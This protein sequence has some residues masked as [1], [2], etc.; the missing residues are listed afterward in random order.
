MIDHIQAIVNSSPD[1]NWSIEMIRARLTG[2]R[3]KNSQ[4]TVIE[5]CQL[6]CKLGTIKK[7]NADKGTVVHY[8]GC[9]REIIAV[10]VENAAPVVIDS[11]PI[12]DPITTSPYADWFGKW[13]VR[14]IFVLF[15]GKEV[16]DIITGWFN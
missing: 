16:S 1:R 3:V 8:E 5:H 15:A 10:M 13:W 9:Y 7:I 11:T 2:M 4:R 6:L 12:L 14:I